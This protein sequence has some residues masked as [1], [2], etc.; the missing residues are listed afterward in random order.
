MSLM[1]RGM[2]QEVLLSL[3]KR[4][5]DSVTDLYQASGSRTDSTTCIALI[6]ESLERVIQFINYIGAS[7]P[8]KINIML[9]GKWTCLR[10]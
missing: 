9:A 7:D 8:K 4:K 1:R 3:M 6:N 2:V 5:I 10:L